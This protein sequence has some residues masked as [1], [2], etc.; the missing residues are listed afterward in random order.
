MRFL[1][2]SRTFPVDFN[3]KWGIHK[4]MQ[5]FIDAIK[6]FAQIDMLIY[7]PKSMV[8]SKNNIQKIEADVCK[9][10]NAAITLY[11]CPLH[12]GLHRSNSN[13]E[14]I[15]RGI[16][17]L[18]HLKITYGTSKKQQVEKFEKHLAATYYDAIFVHRFGSISPI[19]KYRNQLP[20]VFFDLDD[21]EHKAFARDICNPPLYLSK[22]L[23]LLQ[24]P[25]LIWSEY[26]ITSLAK[27]SFVCSDKDRGYLNRIFHSNNI[28]TIP[29]SID[30]PRKQN[31]PNNHNMVFIGILSYFPNIVA[32]EYLIE[33]I[34]PLV[35]KAIPDARLIVAGHSPEKIKYYTKNITGIEFTG[36]VEDLEN[37]YQNARVVCSP[38]FSGGGTRIKIIEAAV[39]GKAVVANKMGAEGLVFKDGDSILLREDAEAFAQA[40][41]R[42]LKDSELCKDIG[43]NARNTAIQYYNKK[44]IVQK[45][46]KNSF[47]IP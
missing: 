20:P 6:E 26:K 45:I 36:Y 18:Y 31:I 40:C 28:V 44:N 1:F 10:F 5:L 17:N 16:F 27:K 7:I 14:L 12:E 41:I 47:G 15:G 46:K 4:R 8:S 34:Y 42:L 29:N 32:V 3:K 9:Y 33:K 24:I 13:W 11:L 25:A 23:Y 21:I 35:R 37:F 39:F 2:V 30:V 43:T 19:L 38:I 22:S